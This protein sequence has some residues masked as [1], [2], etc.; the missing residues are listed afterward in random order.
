MT[1]G[2]TVDDARFRLA[3][4]ELVKLEGA[5]AVRDQARL[6]AE[7]LIR[8]TPPFKHPKANTDQRAG[9]RAV[10]IELA[11]AVHPIQAGKWRDPAIQ[12]AIRRKDAAAMERV[13]SKLRPLQVAPWTVT[14]FHPVLHRERRDG[15]G[16]VRKDWPVATFDVREWRA[17]LRR[18]MGKVGRLKASWAPAARRLG[19]RMPAY[20]AGQP[21]PSGSFEDNLHV[22]GLPSFTMISY[23]KG[24]QYHVARAVPRALLGRAKAMRG[25]VKYLLRARAKKAGL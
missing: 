5:G 10:W 8:K 15:R 7:E 22:A 11:R 1:G 14:P 24:I 19:A 17:Y 20:V 23:G 3:L 2:I 12:L 4:R 18:Q 25:R 9:K 16:K 6:L 21:M 13:L